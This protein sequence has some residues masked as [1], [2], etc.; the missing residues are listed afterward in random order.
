MEDDHHAWHVCLAWILCERCCSVMDLANWGGGLSAVDFPGGGGGMQGWRNGMRGY[1]L[2]A[3][4]Q[5]GMR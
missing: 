4:V 3:S 5:G 2:C 1:V